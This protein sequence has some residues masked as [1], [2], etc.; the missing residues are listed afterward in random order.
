[1][2][3]TQEIVEF[4]KKWENINL[5]NQNILYEYRPFCRNL[6][7]E[8]E[9]IVRKVTN[10]LR[11]NIE[12]WACQQTK[13]YPKHK[14]E[15]IYKEKLLNKDDWHVAD[16]LPQSAKMATNGST[17]GKPFSYLRWEPFLYFIEGENHYDLILDEFEIKIN[18]DILYFIPN[19]IKSEDWISIK[20][21]STNF[22]EHHG[23][24]R[25]A[26]TH[27]VNISKFNEKTEDFF[28]FLF[29][30]YFK[31]YKFDVILATGPNIN[32][33]CHYLRK[34]NYKQQIC[35]LLSNTNEFLL[36]NDINFLFSESY[37]RDICDHMRCWDGGAG[38]FTCKHKNYHIMDNLS[39]CEEAN[40]KLIC[41]DYFSLPSPFVNYWNGDYCKLDNNYNRCD[42]GR[43]YREFKFLQ[44]RPFSLKGMCLKEIQN[45]IR[46][47]NITKIKQIKCGIYKLKVV[48]CEDLSNEE[49]QKI[50]KITNKFEFEFEVEWN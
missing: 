5:P 23:T 38:F 10:L 36:S 4:L 12:L 33:M 8:D 16:M 40:E 20:L 34:L 9:E 2:R 44:N 13:V 26:R 45:Q 19:D 49:K 15:I 18:F 50:N 6:L 48:S 43:L 22:M 14:N 35:N 31:N 32:S 24:K 27:M 25:K 28:S 42:C 41:T 21:N 37:V 30:E 46:S 17:T 47:L 29:F 11:K 3:N 39:W 1:M 7:Y